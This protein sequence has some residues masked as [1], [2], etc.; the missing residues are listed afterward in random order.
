MMAATPPVTMYR[1]PA[2]LR[3]CNRSAWS[4]EPG[5]E[6][7]L[8]NAFPHVRLAQLRMLI[9]NP[10]GFERPG[11]PPERLAHEQLALWVHRR[12]EP[13]LHGLDVI[14]HRVEAAPPPLT[15]QGI[16]VPSP[17]GSVPNLD[18]GL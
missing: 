8:P 14:G 12:D 13:I 15:G 4:S 6:E 9:A 11:R 5:T 1:I 16:D 7:K 17:P 2:T 3:G 18:G 10:C